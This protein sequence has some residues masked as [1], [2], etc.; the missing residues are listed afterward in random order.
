MEKDY[1]VTVIIPVYNEKNII[2]S[3]LNIINDFLKHNF[4]DYEILIVE[5]GSTDGSY[6]ICDKVSSNLKNVKVIHEG[7]RNGFGSALK[8]GYK[9]A[10]KDLVWRVSD[11]LCKQP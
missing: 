1:S 11:F 6:D 10:K 2:V 7:A 5:S 9:N 3:S 8:V 4:K